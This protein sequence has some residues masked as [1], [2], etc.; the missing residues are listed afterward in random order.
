VVAVAVVAAVE[1]E[2]LL[3]DAF[4]KDAQR[5]AVLANRVVAMLTRLIRR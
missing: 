3:G 1:V 5:V 4:Q 2:A